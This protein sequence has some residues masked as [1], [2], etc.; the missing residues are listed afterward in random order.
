MDMQLKQEFL[1]KWK[2]YFG[3]A[4]LPIAFYYTHQVQDADFQPPAKG[5]SCIICEL[6]RVRNGVNLAYGKEAIACS[7]ARR[8]LGYTDKMRPDFEYFL[9]CGIENVMEGERYIRT[10]EMVLE[11]MKNQKTLSRKGEY[12]VFKRW[13]KLTEADQPEVI[14]FFASADTLSG[15]FT[16]A[17]YDQTEPNVTFTPFGSGC[18]SIVHHP[19]LEIDAER[20]RAVI[21]MFDPSARVCVPADRLSFALPYKR[22][23]QMIGYM[24]ESF[25]TT[26]AWSKVRQRMA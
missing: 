22:F 26:P 15:L 14:I 23:V 1:A 7:G 8:Y 25:L 6:A 10:P 3:Q 24:D 4:E 5:R 9:S 11:I 17:N 19:Y 13:D 16:L 12:I 21:G 2:K 20:P 18:S